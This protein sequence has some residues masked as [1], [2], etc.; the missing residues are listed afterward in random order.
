[1]R[2]LPA[3]DFNDRTEAIFV[4]H[5]SPDDYPMNLVFDDDDAAVVRLVQN[6]LVGGPKRN[7]INV[8][9]ECGHQIRPPLYHPR[10]AGDLVED[11]V[12]DVV[13]DDVEEVLAFNELSQRT[14][15]QIEVRRGAPIDSV[16][17]HSTLSM[18]STGLLRLSEKSG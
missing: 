8:A 7:V 4:F 3:F 10:P 9:P 13:A 2:D 17:G 18:R 16:F 15:N 12:D 6:Q 5:A 14:S 1:M 11:F